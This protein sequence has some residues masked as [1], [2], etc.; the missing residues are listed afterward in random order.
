MVVKGVSKC[1]LELHDTG[2]DYFE[3]AIFFVKPEYSGEE[4]S[5][6]EARAAQSVRNAVPP[7]LRRREQ[8]RRLRG[9]FWLAVG[10][11]LGA[12]VTALLNLLF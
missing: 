2:S 1:V 6:L 8:K 7:R 4:N 5:R 3:K 9:G 10:A 12:G 11:A